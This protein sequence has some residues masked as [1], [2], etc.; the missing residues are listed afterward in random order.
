MEKTHLSS[1]AMILAAG[2]GKRLGSLTQKSPKPLVAL[3]NHMRL[4]EGPLNALLSL[5]FKKIII[6]T[7]Y[8]GDQIKSFVKEKY[9]NS[10]IVFSEEKELLETGGGIYNVLDQFEERPFLVCNG[11]IW[12]E[13]WEV[14]IPFIQN[15]KENYD[16]YLMLSSKEKILD[17]SNSGDFFFDSI[18]KKIRFKTEGE[19]SAPTIYMGIAIHR[20]RLFQNYQIPLEK[21]FSIKALW[22]QAQDHERLMGWVQNQS[23]W[24]DCGT[25]SCLTAV[26]KFIL[27]KRL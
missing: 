19:T 24:A 14:L 9:A 1:T 4:I 5:G 7:H 26:N 3:V 13:N 12:L 16:S 2:F 15:Y 10:P 6:N 11:D 20:P 22:H 27:S 18:S 8:L 21:S 23:V 25:P 17:V